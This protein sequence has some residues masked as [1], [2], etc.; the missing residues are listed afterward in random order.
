MELM[1]AKLINEDL[2]NFLLP[3]PT[4]D[5][6]AGLKER[7]LLNL[8]H[9]INRA[10]K[11]FW[12]KGGLKF[13]RETTYDQFEQV[14]NNLEIQLRYT[15]NRKISDEKASFIPVLS[16]LKNDYYGI[17]IILYGFMELKNKKFSDKLTKLSEYTFTIDLTN[18]QEMKNV[19]F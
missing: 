9:E 7:P 18:K 4:A 2:G 19:N 1:K 8:K 3:K 6:K 12:T 14:C 16:T 5:I 10:C 11:T 15:A 13:D 17:K